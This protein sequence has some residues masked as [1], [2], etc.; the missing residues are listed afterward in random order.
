MLAAAAAGRSNEQHPPPHDSI[1]RPST[2]NSFKSPKLINDGRNSTPSISPLSST[3]KAHHDSA[4]DPS[5]PITNGAQIHVPDALD[6]DDEHEQRDRSSS[7]S[8]IEGDFEEQDQEA[9]Q[10]GSEDGLT[11]IDGDE[12]DSEAETER[13]KPTPHKENRTLL[14]AINAPLDAL[15]EDG[16]SDNEST[17]TVDEGDRSR[18]LTGLA[19][20]KRKRILA[21]NLSS[22]AQS[23]ESDSESVL[24]DRR[25]HKKTATEADLTNGDDAVM[26]DVN[27]DE[28]LESD[29]LPLPEVQSPTKELKRGKAK[30][31][32]HKKRVE[33]LLE[34]ED[35]GETE[36]TGE[37]GDEEE[38]EQ[39][40][41]VDP[42][43]LALREQALK[44]FQLL[45]EQFTAL[46]SSIHAEKIAETEAELAQLQQAHPIHPEFIKQLQ[47]V[48]ARRD[49]KIQQ[50]MRLQEY[51]K[52]ALRNSTLAKRAQLLSQYMQE[53]REVREKLLYELGKQW[54]D[55]QKERRAA[56]ADELGNFG[57]VFPTKRSVQV[58]QQ[59]KYN[60]E[61]SVLSGIAK[62]VGFPAA[63]DISGMDSKDVN[64][65][66]A[67]IRTKVQMPPKIMPYPN[68]RATYFG[69]DPKSD[70]SAQKE[71]LEQTPWANPRHPIH[72]QSRTPSAF[73][74]HG[75]Q[76]HSSPGLSMLG[77]QT[78]AFATPQIGA[79]KVPGSEARPP[80][81][82]DTVGVLSD[83]PSSVQPA[84]PTVDRIRLMTYEQGGD[85]S[86]T[87][88]VK[89]VTGAKRDFSGLS[90]A[91]TIDAPPDG[92][93]LGEGRTPGMSLEA[94]QPTQ[95]FATSGLHGQSQE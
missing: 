59:H 63:P 69:T 3:S 55:I 80:G 15:R 44:N 85:T 50:E 4:N 73:G 26:N 51:K 95:V 60:T 1:H 79:D 66:L 56:Q 93:V 34:E 40:D 12:N 94:A 13:I 53:A 84:P 88:H 58:R 28:A 47:A 14:G 36:E 49:L 62:Y 21:R 9:G 48:T 33:S 64:D 10:S 90:S 83:P 27:R 77:K 2:A 41:V 42:A 20:R 71:F 18:P 5:D 72:A 35:T 61:V 22:F 23:D 57:Q 38:D 31:K 67:A 7:L 65:D 78:S 25:G 45:A 8:D 6:Q 74:H 89:R 92:T 86:P 81:S 91:S 37:N 11:P 16:V 68:K 39:A 54:Y 75:L 87:A 30:G 19:G 32:S 46:R 43:E 70:H 29:N 76:N 24:Q 52:Q 82:N 17:A